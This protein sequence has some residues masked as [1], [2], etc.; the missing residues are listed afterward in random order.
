MIENMLVQVKNGVGVAEIVS[1]ILQAWEVAT[2]N[3]R[4]WLV[5][6]YVFYIML[7]RIGKL[8]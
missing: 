4:R 8:A 3:K 6:H 2:A 5:V 1:H 7:I